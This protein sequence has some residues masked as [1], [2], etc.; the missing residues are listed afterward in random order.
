MRVRGI[1]VRILLGRV[2]WGNMAVE[3]RRMVSHVRGGRA[4][5]GRRRRVGHVMLPS[6]RRHGRLPMG[7]CGQM[8][9]HHPGT[10]L[11]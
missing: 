2:R 11:P 4:H 7:H 9:V 5:V 8:M 1:P 6:G 10:F 3:V